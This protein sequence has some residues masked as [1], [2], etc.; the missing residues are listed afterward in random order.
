MRRI[1]IA[2]LL[3]AL[4]AT[5]C[6]DDGGSPIATDTTP[7]ATEATDP[8]PAPEP[9][10]PAPEPAPPAPEP[11]PPAPE[12][13]EEETPISTLPPP[14]ADE[15]GGADTGGF[16]DIGDVMGDDTSVPDDQAAYTEYTVI[17]D[18][19]GA[20]ALE[21]PVEWA[22]QVDGRPFTD[23]QG[24][25]LFDVRAAPDLEQF[26]T[27]WTTP[28]VIVTA[29]REVAQTENEVTLLDEL[30]APLS[31]QCNYLGRQPYS[32]P[33]YDGQVDVYELCGG[34]DVAYVVVGAVPDSR[35]FVIRVQVQVTAE[36]D[37]EALGRVL[38]TFQIVGDV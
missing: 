3:L 34:I 37:L 27:T 15:P 31:S 10:P 36:R 28:G 4:V 9:P 5:A 21:V 2:L 30:V 8:P 35:A 18:D 26:A 14:P 20:I 7:E 25:Q 17:T 6:G 29:S 1:A 13:T 22:A 32:D 23:D 11:P 12:P 24:R 38:Q 16:G 33:L 19:T